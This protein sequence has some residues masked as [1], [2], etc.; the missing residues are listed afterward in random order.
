MKLKV[1]CTFCPRQF[2]KSYIKRHIKTHTDEL[3][4]KEDT[5]KSSEEEAFVNDMEEEEDDAE[6]YNAAEQYSVVS[7]VIGDIIEDA[8]GKQKT[9]IDP[10]PTWFMQTMSGLEGLLEDALEDNNTIEALTRA[11]IIE[12]DGYTCGECG[13]NE[14]IK[15]EMIYHLNQSHGHKI[16]LQETP[17]VVGKTS[18][19]EALKKKVSLY[20]EAIKNLT[21]AKEKVNKEK[22]AMKE[23]KDKEIRAL[24]NDRDKVYRLHEK[25]K[26][27]YFR[28]QGLNVNRIETVIE[29]KKLRE[30]AESSSSALQETLKRNQVLEESL[31]MRDL[32]ITS[33]E[34]ILA[35]K[36][37]EFEDEIKEKNSM[38]RH[39]EEDLGVWESIEP[40]LTAT[41]ELL[42]AREKEAEMTSKDAEEGTI[43]VAK[44]Q[45]CSF[46]TGSATRMKGH[47][48]RHRKYKCDECEEVLKDQA[49][50]TSHVQR[51]HTPNSNIC[52]KCNKQFK[53]K[54]SLKQHM[55][56]QHMET[57][58]V[59]NPPIGHPQW[60]NSRNETRSLQ[61]DYTCNMCENAFETL[62][63]IREHKSKHHQGQNF[64]GFEVVSKT[65]RFFQQG[66]CNRVR[67]SFAHILPSQQQQ[68]GEVE[69]LRGNN[70]RFLAWGSC[71]YYHEGVGVQQP[72]QKHQQRQEWQPRQQ[73]PRQQQPRQQ[74]QR[75]QQ[76]RQQ[77]PRQQQTQVQKMCHF[78]EKCWNQNCTFRHEDFTLAKEFQEN[79]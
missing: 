58:Q 67:C 10:N 68:D 48:V 9:Q 70:C 55:N 3:K 8:I 63:D 38:I 62:K 78:Q 33:L 42:D 29:N 39:L 34:E 72:Q 65:C 35:K 23:D 24:E 71:H 69:C 36:K 13:I 45:E 17:S 28:L 41:N 54:N 7:S 47:M 1:P 75:Q 14:D 4:S 12:C 32:Q 49:H 73:Q 2:A 6:L 74:Q 56:A 51:L 60:A 79:Y 44:C 31:K 52:N 27:S 26:D 37:E 50:L 64:E 21:N 20:E 61:L 19:E 18:G 15:E 53:S 40:Q 22:D 57:H 30:A 43:S 25:A 59:V 16:S 76:Q 5:D 46:S 11:D 77:R 66:R